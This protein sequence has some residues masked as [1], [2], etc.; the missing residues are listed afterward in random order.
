MQP[1]EI[2]FEDQDL[3]VIN[4]PAGVI[5]NRSETVSEETIQDWWQNTLPT[6]PV[7]LTESDRE[8]IPANFTEEFGSAEEIFRER[9]GIVHRLDKETSGVLILAKNPGS[10]VKLLALFRERELSKKYLCLVHGKFHIPEDT[11]SLPLSRSPENRTK[12]TVAGDGRTAETH[13]Q[14]Q[15]FFPGVNSPA[16]I[17]RAHAQQAAGKEIPKPFG[18]RLLQVYQG[19]SL[20]ACWPKTGRTHQIRVHM[21]HLKHP[22]ISYETYLGK[23]RY[24]FDV[25]WCPRL[26][27]HAT[28]ITFPHPRTGQNMTVSAPL[29]ADLTQALS[30]LVAE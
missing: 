30:Y 14:V 2:L 18:K 27:L 10:L 5:V 7:T 11:V 20:V 4:K 1:I 21:A 25:V 29:P 9:G 28:E 23:K 6:F 8:M 19:F 24:N 26:F 17:E 12:F 13:Y 3:A 22:I 15:H 16:V